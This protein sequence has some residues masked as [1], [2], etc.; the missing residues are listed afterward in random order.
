MLL[1]ERLCQYFKHYTLVRKADTWPNG[2]VKYEIQESWG[3]DQ[4]RFSARDVSFC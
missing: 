2:E 1:S 4:D 3:E